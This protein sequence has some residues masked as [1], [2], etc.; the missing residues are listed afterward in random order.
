MY[1]VVGAAMLAGIVVLYIEPNRSQSDRPPR[2]DLLV[3]GFQ[4]FD[5]HVRAEQADSA[6]IVPAVR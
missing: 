3:S 4:L 6:T 5:F 1:L 2:E